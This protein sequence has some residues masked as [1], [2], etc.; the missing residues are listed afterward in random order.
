MPPVWP[1]VGLVLAVGGDDA[2]GTVGTIP[3]GGTVSESL[4]LCETSV[5]AKR[6]DMVTGAGRAAAA[7]AIFAAARFAAA[8][9]AAA[10]G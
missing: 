10:V 9:F 4:S 7:T 6:P 3:P 2:G 1:T 5:I 8:R